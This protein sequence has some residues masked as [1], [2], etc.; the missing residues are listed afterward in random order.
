MEGGALGHAA[1]DAV[2][3]SSSSSDDID[4]GM[5][6]SQRSAK[7]ALGRIGM[8]AASV[9]SVHRDQHMNT[10]AA[11]LQEVKHARSALDVQLGAESADRVRLGEELRVISAERDALTEA[12]N[13]ALAQINADAAT[14]RETITALQSEL[15]H[16]QQVATETADAAKEVCAHMNDEHATSVQSQADDLRRLKEEADHQTQVHQDNT[17]TIGRLRHEVEGAN[18]RIDQLQSECTALEKSLAWVGLTTPVQNTKD[19]SS[20][21]AVAANEHVQSELLRLQQDAIEA[22]EQL[23]RLQVSMILSAIISMPPHIT[24]TLSVLCSTK[25]PKPLVTRTLW[26]SEC[27]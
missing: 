1:S 8:E 5:S 2:S 25:P 20:E 26:R 10:L 7:S 21:N 12:R 27:D 23:A 19:N 6:H 3:T 14:S 16:M 11:E 4:Q 15:V 9:Q 22:S 13:S 24:D 18:A 17:V